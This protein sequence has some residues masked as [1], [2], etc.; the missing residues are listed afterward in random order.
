MQYYMFELDKASKKQCTI[1]TP[2]GNFK[3]E[4]LHM[5]LK[6]LQDYAQEVMENIF[7][8]L[9]DTDVYIDNVGSFSDDWK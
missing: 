3:Y 7:R 5:G 2:F 1:V 4:R 8:D 6:F 9:E